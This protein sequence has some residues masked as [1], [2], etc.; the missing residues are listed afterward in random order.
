V[1]QLSVRKRPLKDYFQGCDPS[2]QDLIIKML[3]FSPNRRITIEDALK[4]P[5]L[6]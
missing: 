1:N 5:C 4:H 3:E 6:K 2:L